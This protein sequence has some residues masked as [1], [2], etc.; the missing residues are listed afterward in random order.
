MTVIRYQNGKNQIC[1]PELS[2]SCATMTPGLEGLGPKELM[3]ASLGLC[4][5]ITLTSLLERDGIPL[6]PG[7]MSIAVTATKED[8]V[9]NRFTDFLVEVDFPQM[10]PAYKAKA[11]LIVERGCTISNTLRHAGRVTLTDSGRGA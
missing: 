1:G 9:T 4:T 8:G 5:S 7:G 2:P 11:M 3:E 10:E 6:S